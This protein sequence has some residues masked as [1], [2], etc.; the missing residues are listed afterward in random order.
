MALVKRPLVDPAPPTARLPDDLAV[1]LEPE[2][3]RAQGAEWRQ[4]F[5]SFHQLGISFEWHDFRLESPMD[6]ARSFH[7]GCLEIC[8]NLSGRGWVSDGQS[9]VELDEQTVGYYFSG[10]TALEA[11]REPGQPHRFITIE[12]S[13]RFLSDQLGNSGVGLNPLVGNLVKTSSETSRVGRSHRLTSAQL[14]IVRS[15]QRPPVLAA[16]QSIWYRGKALELAAAFLYDPPAEAEL[17]CHRQHHVASERVRRVIELLRAQLAEPLS[18]EFLAK[19][20]GCSQFYLSR[21]FSRETG[22]TIAQ[23]LRKLRMEKAAELL[24]SGKYNVTEAA[25]EVGYNSLSHFSHTFHQTYGCCP[26]LYPVMKAPGAK[27]DGG[28]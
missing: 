10:E 26:G 28:R 25:L 19:K 17:F 22:L 15:L 20:V 5:G 14:E 24:R 9:R 21:T 27:L 8:L 3:W 12:F 11:R 4:L 2:V 16:A 1:L 23:Y 7:R 13:R 6:W 18:L